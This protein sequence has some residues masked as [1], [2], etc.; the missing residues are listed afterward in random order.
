[1][2]RSPRWALSS[3]Q[4]FPYQD[5]RLIDL[6]FKVLKSWKPD[7]VD[8][9]GDTSDA[10]C[11]ARFSEGRSY[12][13]IN[14]VAKTS[15]ETYFPYVYEE[16]LLTREFFAQTRKMLPDAEIFTALGNHENRLWEYPDKKF[17]EEAHLITPE[18]LW[19]LD[20]LGIDYIYYNDPPKHRYGD[21]FVHH[22]ISISKNAGESVKNDVQ[23]FGVSIIR[24]HSHRMG[25]YFKTHELRNDGEGE[26]LRGYEIGHLNNPKSSGFK[27]SQRHDWQPGFAIAEIVDGYPHVQLILINDYTC[28]VNGK[29]FKA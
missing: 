24:G 15:K 5:N 8:Y 27:Y 12:E 10:A 25:S 28:V 18:S 26:T 3:D 7:I 19:H 9:L 13:F 4:H 11:F 21:I 1:M 2:T 23:D 17:P 29:V 6:W 14:Q 16:E 22:G 20:T